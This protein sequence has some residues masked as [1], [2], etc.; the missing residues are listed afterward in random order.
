MDNSPLVHTPAA[1]RRV[2]VFLPHP[3]LTIAPAAGSVIRGSD[4]KYLSGQ[5]RSETFRRLRVG[6]FVTRQAL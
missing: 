6:V 3:P 5:L 2:Y 4:K 1:N